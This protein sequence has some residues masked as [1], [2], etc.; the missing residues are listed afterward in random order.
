MINKINQINNPLSKAWLILGISC[1]GLAGLFAILLVLARTPVINGFIPHQDFFYS[2]LVVHVNL[3]VL[4]WLLSISNSLNSLII[5]EAMIKHITSISYLAYFATLL[6]VISPWMGGVAITNNYIPMLQNLSFIVGLALLFCSVLMQNIISLISHIKLN[7]SKKFGIYIS[8]LIQLISIAS[9]L[10][11]YWQLKALNYE[12]NIHQFYELLFW[13]AGHILQFSY[14]QLLMISWLI[15]TD[16]KKSFKKLYYLLFSLN[17]IIIL[18][19]IKPH[20]LHHIDDE[21]FREYFT[22]HMR[23]YGGLIPAIMAIILIIDA[24]RNNSFTKLGISFW[25][26]GILFLVG[27]V[28]GLLISGLN[29]T[30][31]A[32]YHGSV[33]GVSVAAMGVAYYLL[34]R[35]GYQM[36]NKLAVNCQSIILTIGQIIHILGL[37]YSGKSGVLRKSPGASAP[38]ANLG[39]Y[40]MAI[41]G[42]LAVIGGVWFIINCIKS[43]R[44]NKN[45]IRD[46]NNND[47]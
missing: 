17:L 11:S 10:Y 19:T 45:I 39:M 9:L 22:I 40:L 36:V 2:A 21:Q 14:T 8:S 18:L 13:S 35:F 29:V 5:K 38:A 26:S 42:L 32:H 46:K 6:I 47:L 15:L 41:G 34:P 20:L 16:F 12:L 33:V 31:P 7:E 37:A 4:I 24:K 43:I 1:L 30:I 3:S 27:G 28:I 25:C 44:F 23:H